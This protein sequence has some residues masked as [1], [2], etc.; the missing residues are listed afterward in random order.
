MIK[1]ICI[2]IFTLSSFSVLSANNSL[3]YVKYYEEKCEYNN[4]IIE[5]KKLLNNKINVETKTNIYSTLVINYVLT[6]DTTNCI[7][8]FN[9]LCKIDSD[10]SN[11]YVD[12]IRI[13]EGAI[14]YANYKA[15][16]T[17]RVTCEYIIYYKPELYRLI[18]KFNS[19]FKDYNEKYIRNR[20][21]DIYEENLATIRYYEKYYFYLNESYINYLKQQSHRIFMLNKPINGLIQI[22]SITCGKRVDYFEIDEFRMYYNSLIKIFTKE[23]IQS[24][25]DNPI[26]EYEEIGD[27]ICYYWN[28]GKGLKVQR[29]AFN[30]KS[31]DIE[32]GKKDISQFIKSRKI[33]QYIQT[34]LNNNTPF[35]EEVIVKVDK[36]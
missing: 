22:F 31:E 36:K 26:I 10:T 23:E 2:F 15:Y 11:Y 24:I 35:I 16:Y 18:P 9:E 19:L 6:S 33:I 13:N 34:Q 3:V 4:A 32:K 20:D 12:S 28:L 7:Y 8:Y 29:G 30:K 1:S 17:Y 27:K 14:S 21:R 5:C 25:I